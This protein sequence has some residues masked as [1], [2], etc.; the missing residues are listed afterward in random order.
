MSALRARLRPAAGRSE[1]RVQALLRSVSDVI[2][3]LDADGTLRYANP[4]AERAWGCRVDELVGRNLLDRVHPDDLAAASQRLSSCHDQPDQTFLGQV[5]LRHD[6]EGWRDFEV[7]VRNLMDDP[8]VGGII[9]TYRDVTERKAFERKLSQLA[10]SDPLTG[11]A[12]R[13]LFTERLER[14]VAEAEM[15]GRRLGLLFIDLDN[16]KLV[17]DG[18]GHAAGDKVLLT[19]ADRLRRCLRSD[20]TIARLGGDEFTILIEDLADHQTAVTIAE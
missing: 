5:R 17:N 8:A 19:V 9:A 15:A 12:N 7:I 13:A 3:V 4:A 1:E 14:A 10:F 11:L 2:A 18:L 6:T 16:F 20:C